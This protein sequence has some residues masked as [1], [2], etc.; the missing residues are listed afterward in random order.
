MNNP[1]RRR[2][3][4]IPGYDYAGPGMYFVT[5]CTRVREGILGEVVGQQVLLSPE[6]RI[7]AE[8]W[9]DI[10][11]HF[12]GVELDEWIVMPNHVHGIIV[13]EGRGE[14]FGEVVTRS[15]GSSPPNASPLHIPRPHGTAKGSVGAVVQNY[16]S[17]SSRWINRVRGAGGRSVWQRNYYEHVIRGDDDLARIRTYI[18]ENPLRWELDEEN[19][20][21]REATKTT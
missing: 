3:T 20:R 18:T 7:A 4:R 15:D 1:S 10:P 8:Y 14:A 2:S 21:R 5:I 6:G 16:K 11:R 9:R 13:I 17:V 12:P 19:P